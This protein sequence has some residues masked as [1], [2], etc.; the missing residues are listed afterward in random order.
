MRC[1][2]AE[3][4]VF[5]S[6]LGS[7]VFVTDGSR[8]YDL[9]PD[10]AAALERADHRSVDEALSRLGITEGA[11]RFISADAPPLPALHALSLT[12]AQACNMGCGYCYAD[13]G[14]FGG[15]SRMMSLETAMAGVDRLIMESPPGSDIVLGFMGG[16]PLLN[17][18][19]VHA[20]TRYAQEAAQSAGRRMRFSITTNGTLIT[21]ED[22][23]LFA[24]YR[25]NVAISVDGDRTHNDRVR[26]MHN[27]TG[28]Y[29]RILA[30]LETLNRHGRPRHLSARV[31]VTPKAGELAPTLDHIIGLGFDSVGFA[32]VLTSP[33]PA[34]AFKSADFARFLDEMIVC[35]RIALERL[36]AGQRYPFS[37]FE[38]ALHEI[39]R[40][41]HRPY[42]CGAGAGYLS[43]NAEGGLFACHRLVD[44]P[45]FAM[46]DLYS[47]SDK[48]L[49]SQHLRRSHVDRMAPCSGCWARYLC[50][51]GCYHEVA[52]RGRDGCDYIRGWLAFCLASY[53]E[54]SEV[55]PDYFDSAPSSLTAGLRAN[56]LAE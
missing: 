16:E 20:T 6:T 21:A 48:A 19:V 42:P 14:R 18:S 43:A 17:R 2:S 22:A 25:F 23:A 8:I 49:R 3:A 4:L 5:E 15:A 53:A 35:G 30:G 26:R 7:H 28:S 27:G 54:L 41:T 32:A 9:D 31:T 12:V 1:V 36:T 33:N 55:R 34:L 44:T 52:K 50:G 46:G 56:T 37:N 11:T 51:G 40:G 29:D 10:S 24:A 45:E 39:H 38:T 47:G 13:E